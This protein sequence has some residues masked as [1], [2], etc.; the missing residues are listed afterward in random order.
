MSSAR[1]KRKLDDYA[2][3]S[4]ETPGLNA[5]SL[6]ESFVEVGCLLLHR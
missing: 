2:Y 6:T 3:T 4:P 5:K 1:L